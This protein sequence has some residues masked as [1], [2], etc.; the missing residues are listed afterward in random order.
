MSSPNSASVDPSS[1]TT[2][3]SFTLTA[4]ANGVT[5][6]TF[7][8][9]EHPLGDLLVRESGGKLK[10]RCNG[11]PVSMDAVDDI[12]NKDPQEEDDW[13]GDIEELQE[14]VA[15][16]PKKRDFQPEVVEEEKDEAEDAEDSDDSSVNPSPPKKFKSSCSA[17]GKGAPK[18][19][20]Y[21]TEEMLTLMEAQMEAHNKKKKAEEQANQED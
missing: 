13:F 15:D 17:G 11:I 21:N 4:V 18:E 9:G 14:E 12:Q 19:V 20:G 6:F 2:S 8:C 1:A 10:L 16:E 5:A 7:H 3:Y